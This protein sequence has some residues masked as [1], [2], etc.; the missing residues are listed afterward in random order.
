MK[1]RALKEPS[2]LRSFPNEKGEF[3][4]SDLEPGSYALKATREGYS[5]EY[6][7]FWIAA[8]KV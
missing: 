7:Q 1:R 6:V 4:L 2:L 5:T 3:R 8:A